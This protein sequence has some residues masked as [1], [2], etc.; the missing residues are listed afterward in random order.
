M[1][2][3]LVNVLRRRRN[4]VEKNLKWYQNSLPNASSPVLYIIIIAKVKMGFC[5]IIHCSF[6]YP[7]LFFS[8]SLFLPVLLAFYL[9][10]YLLDKSIVLT[11]F[12]LHY[13]SL[14]L[15]HLDS[16]NRRE[17]SIYK[18]IQVN[19]YTIHGVPS[20][21]LDAILHMRH[22]RP[23]LIQGIDDWLHFLLCLSIYCC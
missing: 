1:G 5:L 12:C 7:Q 19:Y 6:W 20:D 13:L 21:I 4:L 11:P 2:T 3:A 16:E 17:E 15:I 23:L 22:L 8:S 14:L 9:N 10:K 18:I